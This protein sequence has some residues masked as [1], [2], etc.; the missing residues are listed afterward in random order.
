MSYRSTFIASPASDT[1]FL[2][3]C[4]LL[5]L[6]GLLLLVHN[7]IVTLAAFV[8]FTAVYTAAHHLPGF[9]R[10]Y[11][12]RDIFDANRARLLLAPV[13]L[14]ATLGYLEWNGMRGYIVVL[15]FF[16]WWHTAMQ[17]Y[18]LM[19]IYERKSLPAVNYSVK[20]DLI[21]IIVWHFTASELLSDD[22]RF[23][24]SQ[25]LFNLGVESA[26]AVSLMLWSL[27][28]I[29]VAASVVLL[30]LYV[31]NSIAQFKANAT[32][33][34]N[35]QIFL[36]TTYGLYFFMF[37]FFT[38]DIST[39]VESFFHNTQYL[40]FAW[41]L[42][43]RLAEKNPA[44]GVSPF[45]WFGSLF[46]IR[47]KGPAILVYG[48]AIVVWGYF[49]GGSIKPRI[50]TETLV[51]MF[52]V[53]Y[54]TSAFLHYYTDSFIWKARTREMSAT[55]GLKGAGQELSNRSYSFSFAEVAAMLLIPMV[56]ATALTNPQNP[57]HAGVRQNAG[58]AAFS[59][60]LLSDRTMWPNAAVAA[61]DVGDF[62]ATDD[63]PKAVEW[64]RRAVAVRGDY[65]DAYQALGHV[66]SQE[67]RPREAA[68]AYEKA[69]SLD[70]TFVSSWNNLGNAYAT[71]GQLDK[72]RAAYERTLALDPGFVEGHLNLAQVLAGLGDPA[73]AKGSYE[74]ALAIDAQS[75]A[76]VRG[77]GHLEAGLGNYADAVVHFKRVVSLTPDN[78]VAHLDLSKALFMKRDFAEAV[79]SIDALIKL[80]PAQAAGY[81]G[82]AQIHLAQ[83]ST[84]D[85]RAD[86]EQAVKVEPASAEA[87]QAIG[88]L[89]AKDGR[90]DAALKHLE[91]SV[92]LDPSLADSYFE[93]AAIWEK[94]GDRSLAAM[95]LN[96]AA[97][98]GHQPSRKKLQELL[99]LQRGS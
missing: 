88:V 83:N 44:A 33:A 90:T 76:A 28:W 78:P 87:Q 48:A 92:R 17:N 12:T 54:A 35:K 24:L 71:M 81:I 43:R 53:L 56:L 55:L 80:S 37:Y 57:G 10:A 75:V 64:Y 51:P 49:M 31:R 25:H 68:E 14:L 94:R 74:R 21:S 36:L 59:A 19:R 89:Y 1:V 46:S 63:P 67:R 96:Q 9:L 84:D 77:L 29:G 22:M 60:S 8:A 85:A 70:P 45:N 91:E 11:G 50:S 15:W 73:A 97:R 62:I 23:E 30:V 52:N 2:L 40:F 3:A 95:Y 47:G 41:V 58:L 38:K 6:G 79:A 72:A 34:L 27:R 32:V 86:L 4:P 42:Q 20:L 66:Y 5:V 99:A 65:A 7:G 39:S 98:F 61:A 13:L 93:I 82:R 18:G 69:V 16:N 26:A